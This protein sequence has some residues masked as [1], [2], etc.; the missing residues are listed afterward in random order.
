MYSTTGELYE[1][2]RYEVDQSHK[3]TPLELG[4]ADVVSID[5]DI[6]TLKW[7]RN[8]DYLVM[9]NLKVLPED[10][11]K[12]SVE[13]FESTQLPKLAQKPAVHPNGDISCGF[14]AK[15]CTRSV[16][17]CLPKDYVLKESEVLPYCAAIFE[18]KGVATC[19]KIQNRIFILD[20]LAY[21]EDNEGW[22]AANGTDYVKVPCNKVI[23]ANEKIVE[24]LLRVKDLRWLIKNI[25]KILAEVV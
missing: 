17:V 25:H 11:V 2:G 14:T 24:E 7:T 23:K 5:F 16:K 1:I 22:D 15:G 20:Q 12:V 8:G 4:A 9:E 18:H 19:W 21:G 3:C 10:L 13:I 6:V